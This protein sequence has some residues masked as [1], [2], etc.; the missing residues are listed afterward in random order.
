MLSDFVMLNFVAICNG[1]N[2]A[3]GTSGQVEGNI[4]HSNQL[5]FLHLLKILLKQSSKIIVDHDLE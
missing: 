3:Q 2:T 4:Q 1:I 5:K